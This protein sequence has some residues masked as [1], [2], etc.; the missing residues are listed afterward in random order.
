VFSMLDMMTTYTLRV[1]LTDFNGSSRFAVYNNFRIA[2][3]SDKYRLLTL[4]KYSGTA[5]RPMCIIYD[6]LCVMVNL[7]HVKNSV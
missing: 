1:D 2:S 3:S 6:V 4:G 7:L 5:G